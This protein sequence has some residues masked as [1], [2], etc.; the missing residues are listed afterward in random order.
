MIRY[1]QSSKD[2]QRDGKTHFGIHVQR[3]QRSRAFHFTLRL[4]HGETWFL[5]NRGDISLSMR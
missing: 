1:K 5:R 3:G 4:L 2:L